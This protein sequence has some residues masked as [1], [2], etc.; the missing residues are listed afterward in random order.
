MWPRVPARA[1][2]TRSGDL[3]FIYATTLACRLIG[4][5]GGAL[6]GDRDRVVKR[7]G[8]RDRSNVQQ[9]R[10]LVSRREE[11]GKIHEESSARYSQTRRAAVAPKNHES[12]VIRMRNVPTKGCRFDSESNGSRRLASRAFLSGRNEYRAVAPPLLLNCAFNYSAT[13]A[14]SYRSRGSL[15]RDNLCRDRERDKDPPPLE[16][17]RRKRSRSRDVISALFYA[18]LF[19]GDSVL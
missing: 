12:A 8:S 17:K 2:H 3:D 15:P 14:R 1:P 7:H 6:L 18:R 13:G 9:S 10:Y 11:T 19:P 5:L 4:R 16:C